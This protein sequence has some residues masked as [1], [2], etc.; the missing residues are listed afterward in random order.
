MKKGKNAKQ[1][2]RGS[3]SSSPEF[4]RGCRLGAIGQRARPTLN[5]SSST[6]IEPLLPAVKSISQG[7]WVLKDLC[8]SL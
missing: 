4:S 3:L 6:T 2:F 5:C 8:K 7:N 1:G